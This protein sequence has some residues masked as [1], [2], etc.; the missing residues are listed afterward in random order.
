[1]AEDEEDDNRLIV[2][3]PRKYILPKSISFGYN[4]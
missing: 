1:M 2:D 3:N 4:K